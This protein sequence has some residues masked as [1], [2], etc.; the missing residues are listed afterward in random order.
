MDNFHFDMTCEGDDTLSAAMLVVFR[1]TRSVGLGPRGQK[2]GVTHYAIR[3]KQDK[4]SVRMVFFN[5]VGTPSDHMKLPFTF[6]AAGAADFARRWLSEVE[7]G[8]EP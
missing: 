4:K 3:P 5:Y 6:D 1:A 2:L 7:Y 8:T